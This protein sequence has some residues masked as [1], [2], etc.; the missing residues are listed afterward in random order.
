MA[1]GPPTQ[2]QRELFQ[3]LSEGVAEREAALLLVEEGAFAELMRLAG[4][5][6]Q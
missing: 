3:R 1:D 6:L 4:V 2:G 5:V